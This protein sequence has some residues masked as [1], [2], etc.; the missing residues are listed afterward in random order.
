MQVERNVVIC[1]LTHDVLNLLKKCK[2]KEKR[3]NRNDT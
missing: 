2:T 1:E 3:N